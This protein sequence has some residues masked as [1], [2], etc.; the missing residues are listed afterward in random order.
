ALPIW[1]LAEAVRRTGRHA[2]LLTCR[3]I[4][5]TGFVYQ[6]LIGSNGM[7]LT[8]GFISLWND[9]KQGIF[10]Q[11]E[12]LPHPTDKGW[13]KPENRAAKR[14]TS[15]WSGSLFAFNRCNPF[16]KC[17]AIQIPLLHFTKQVARFLR[18][19]FGIPFFALAGL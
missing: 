8:L 4:A 16:A 10:P 6:W 18:G 5:K 9:G 2:K 14:H 17:T 11:S 12:R 13:L 19:I 1:R 7:F 15:R 3:S